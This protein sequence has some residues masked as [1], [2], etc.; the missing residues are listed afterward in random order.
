MRVGLYLILSFAAVLE[1]CALAFMW[2]TPSD[3]VAS[4]KER[5]G[6]ATQQVRPAI[7]AYAGTVH[8]DIWSSAK[9]A[10]L[11][12]EEQA[13]LADIF[14]WQLDFSRDLQPGDRWRLTLDERV[15]GPKRPRAILAAEVEQGGVIFQAVRFVS[16][17]STRYFATDGSSLERQFLHSPLYQSHVTS[18]FAR[19]RFH[20]ILK[21]SLPHLGVD[22]GAPHG[23]P[24][25][26]AGAGIVLAAS[27]QGGAGKTVV[28]SHGHRYQT[29]YKHLSRF[30]RYLK[31]GQRVKMG[32][33]IAFVGA[34]GL[35]TGPHLHYEFYDGAHVI[36]P[37]AIAFPATRAVAAD[38]QAAF[39]KIV[40]KE[41]ANLPPWTPRA[42]VAVQ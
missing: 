9:A 28:I 31:V 17:T 25:L 21:V 23:T 24:V 18:A 8:S 40:A 34:T 19:H 4:A 16:A 2:P 26:A 38:E 6:A 1:W 39:Q 12:A 11:G 20:P 22:Y 7:T 41:Q 37:Q 15:P 33:I 14:A 42:E 13:Q 30:A 27:F 35:A 10:G 3:G 5:V 29:R 36:N 32:D